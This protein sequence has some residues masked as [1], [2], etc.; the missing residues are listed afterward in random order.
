[1][2]N[3]QVLVVAAHPDDEVLGCGGTLS[4]HISSG[5]AVSVLIIAEGVT[6]RKL[7]E[8]IN[9]EKLNELNEASKKSAKTLGIYD[10]N[11]LGYPDNKLDSII[12]LDV[13]K[14]IEFY[15]NKIKPD[16]VYT[17]FDN[18][19]NIDHKIT[20]DAVLTAC[21][22]INDCSVKTIYAYE[23]LSSTEWYNTSTNNFK[24]NHFV[25]ISDH[26]ET[27]LNALKAYEQEMRSFP[28]PRSYKSI[29][30]LAE[31]RGSTVGY[32]AAEAFMLIRHQY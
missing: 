27:K 8:E 9:N 25:D 5:D 16:I 29:K 10:L 28:H 11:Y 26:L 30:A 22:P 17:H 7:E 2:K 6:S 19:L 18:D 24:P 4:R 1:M 15:I 21:R 32:M 20:S 14:S 13:V 31:Y 3:K 23:T 12:F